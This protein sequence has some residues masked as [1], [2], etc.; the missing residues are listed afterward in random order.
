[1]KTS[2]AIDQ[3]AGALAK[4]QGQ[5]SNVTKDKINPHFKSGYASLDS[6]LDVIRDVFA[7]HDLALVQGCAVV[8]EEI[9]MRSRVIHKSGQ[10]IETELPLLLTKND[11]QGMGSGISYARRYLAQAMAGIAQA[12]EDND[13]QDA[14]TKPATKKPAAPK[15]I[16]KDAPDVIEMKK[17]IKELGRDE[18]SY[19]KH[20]STLN[21]REITNLNQ[22]DHKESIAALTMLGDLLKKQKGNGHAQPR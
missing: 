21:K 9:L 20:L 2:E 14:A 17:M 16:S 22:L 19:L 6:T 7:K 3:I 4:A 12:D 13:G 5:L 15:L 1:M 8:G 18:E 11:M 10:W